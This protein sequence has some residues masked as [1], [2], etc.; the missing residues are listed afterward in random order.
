MNFLT[1]FAR[2]L[3]HGPYTEPFPF[4]PAPTPARLRGRITF[5]APTCEGC[6]VCERMCPA[7]A[8]R[9]TKTADGLA[10]AC[11]HNSC[12]FCGNCEFYC[13]TKSIRQTT[14]WRLAHTQ[15]HKYTL[16]EFGLI[17]NMKCAECGATALATVPATASVK[18]P[19]TDEEF[20]TMKTLCPKCR[21]KFMI[22]RKV[23]P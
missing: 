9:F 14:D 16:A 8:I 15:A 10:F 17:P 2:N 6:R 23:K 12:V 11:W 1:L 20:A 7:G 3:R 18:P 21:A 13:P 4:G 5:D 22:A 19:F